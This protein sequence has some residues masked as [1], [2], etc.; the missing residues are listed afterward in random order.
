[1]WKYSMGIRLP[2][3][4]FVNTCATLRTTYILDIVISIRFLTVACDLYISSYLMERRGVFWIKVRMQVDYVSLQ[5]TMVLLVFLGWWQWW[6]WWCWSFHWHPLLYVKW[7]V[8]LADCLI[9][10]NHLSSMG[11]AGSICLLMVVLVR[12]ADSISMLI[13]ELCKSPGQVLECQ[14]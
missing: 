2:V 8:W 4:L 14:H 7:E 3:L 9:I 10:L 11:S 5:L 12:L 6:C 13:M 1:M